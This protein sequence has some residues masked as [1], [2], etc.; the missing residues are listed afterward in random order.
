MTRDSGCGE[1]KNHVC[2]ETENHHK[3]RL[4][5]LCKQKQQF[6]RRRWWC[7]PIPGHRSASTHIPRRADSADGKKKITDDYDDN[8]IAT[9]WNFGAFFFASDVPCRGRRTRAYGSNDGRS[10]RRVRVSRCRRAAFTAR[11]LDILPN[12][13]RR[14]LRAFA[15]VYIRLC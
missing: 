13:N 8:V 6:R 14:R 7:P 15:C 1:K 4:S 5:L 3:R 9:A 11:R 12:I 2:F 10:V